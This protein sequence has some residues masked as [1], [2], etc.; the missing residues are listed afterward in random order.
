MILKNTVLFLTVVLGLLT[1]SCT[2]YYYST[3]QSYD[4]QLP[5]DGSGL[6]STSRNEI[7]VTYSFKDSGGKIVYEIHN[8]S[9]DPVF[10]D[11]SRSVIIAEDHA[12]QLRDRD[13]YF[14]GNVTT[15][16]YQFSN[17]DYVTSAGSISGRV[18]LPQN[19]LFIPP[20]S[21][22]IHSPMSLSSVLDLDI[23]KD[24][25]MKRDIGVSS[26][27]FIDFTENDT[28]LKFR[29]YLTIV[30]DR[31]KSQTVFEDTFFISEIVRTGA[32][33]DRLHVDVQRRNNLFYIEVLNQ[34][35]ATAGWIIVGVAT[36]GGLI[37][38]S[39]QTPDMPS[40]SF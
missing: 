4:K 2:T 22:V 25:Y 19:D 15:T 10:V 5:Q 14:H 16:T 18:V 39:S 6:F 13:A 24:V 34:K 23:P 11:W 8:N 26:V 29:S 33:N 31:D 3:V 17:S 20:H 28:P 32:R 40:T 1:S 37:L 21:K 38:L 12:I 36:L 35:A 30:N 9:E 27:Y 7:S